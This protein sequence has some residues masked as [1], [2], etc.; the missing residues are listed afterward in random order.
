MNKK[1]SIGIVD[2]GIGNHLS[3]ST[4][5]KRV[6]IKSFISSSI[7]ELQSADILL[8]PGVGS[9]P[10]A[11]HNLNSSGLSSFLQDQASKDRSIIGICLGMQLLAESSWEVDHTN[12]LGIIPGTFIS[13]PDNRWHIGWNSLDVLQQGNLLLDSDK[14]VVY[15]NHSFAYSGPEKYILIN[16]YIGESNFRIPAAIGKGKVIGL[17]FHPEKSQAAGL[18]LL[19]NLLH[20]ITL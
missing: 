6:G 1:I 4:A 10:I 12:G 17:Q 20:H 13:L 16:S 15:F 3:V 7:P 19:S 5:L 18:N 11:M 8:L 14:Q 2:Y 9:F